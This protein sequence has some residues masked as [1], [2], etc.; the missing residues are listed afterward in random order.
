MTE[1]LLNSLREVF[2]ARA[3]AGEPLSRHTSF[4]I[5]GP[6]DVWVEVDSVAEVQQVLS[7]A[8]RAAAPLFVLGGGTNLLVSDRGVRGIV[9]KLGRTF[10]QIEWHPNGAGT[11]V[12]AG[13]AAPFKKLVTEAVHRALA[14]L[15]FAEGIPGSLGGGLLMNAGAFGGEIAQVIEAIEGV[16]AE[17]GPQ[18]LPREVLRFGYRHFDLPRGFVV[19]HLALRLLPGDAEAVRTRKL[20]YKRRRETHQP[21]GY[22][23]AGSIFKNPPG[24]YAGRLIEAAGFKG[25]RVGGAMVSEQHAN[26]IVNAGGATAADVRALMAEIVAGVQQQHQV[27]LQPEVKLVGDWGTSA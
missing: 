10:A 8:H 4:R 19:T 14:G 23:N 2:G 6:A 5:G 7:A 3:R 20:E 25:R 24:Q 1:A 9:M 18:R 17:R 11:H 15:E 13:A 27:T 22:P 26:F 16:D 21:L 12:Y